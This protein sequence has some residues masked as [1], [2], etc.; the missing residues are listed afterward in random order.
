MQT[1]EIQEFPEIEVSDLA[2]DVAGAGCEEQ[3]HTGES[4]DGAGQYGNYWTVDYRR[5]G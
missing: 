5:E 3:V 2:Y 1:P 4:N